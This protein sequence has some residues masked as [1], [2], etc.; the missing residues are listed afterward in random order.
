MTIE[1]ESHKIVVLV[2]VEVYRGSKYNTN[3]NSDEWEGSS[4]GGPA[5]DILIFDRYTLQVG[6]QNC[7]F[8]ILLAEAN[9]ESDI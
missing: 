3:Q 7:Y 5:T 4:D 6:V 1:S 9:N 8:K 2:V